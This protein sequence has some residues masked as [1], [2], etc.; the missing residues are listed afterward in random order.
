MVLVSL[1]G[2]MLSMRN[3]L[4]STLGADYITFAHAKGLSKRRIMIHY[5]ARNAILPNLTG[6]GMA[7]GFVLSGALLTEIIFSYPGQGYLFIAPVKSQ[8]FPLMQGLFMTI[9][10]AV[11]LAN[12]LVDIAILLLIQG[13]ENK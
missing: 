9:T 10:L 3:T 6:F 8:D 7:L 1:G 2:W 11:L 4:I 5:A 13:Q 12:W